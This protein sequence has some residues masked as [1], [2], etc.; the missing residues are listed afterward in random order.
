MKEFIG[1]SISVIG[2]I[3][4]ALPLLIDRYSRWE[5]FSWD[6]IKWYDLVC[7]IALIASVIALLF[8][9]YNFI[10]NTDKTFSYDEKGREKIAEYLNKK[11]SNSQKVAIFSRDL[12]WVVKGSPQYNT[13]EKKSKNR[14]LILFLEKDTDCSQYF[15]SL[16]AEV[17]KYNTRSS[18]GYNP[19][20]RFTILNFEL[21]GK[22][23]LIGFK[24]EQGK[25]IIRLVNFKEHPEILDI[26]DDYIS[27]LRSFSRG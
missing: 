15:A 27:F 7:V 12:T 16:G 26:M 20:I 18:R 8:D 5:N 13:L 17:K 24:N 1:R 22:Q 14:E 10:V 23:A 4:T 11:I 6:Y 25:H 9:I 21:S 19:K 3:I 2:V